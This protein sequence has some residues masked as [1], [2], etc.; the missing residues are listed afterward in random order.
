MS[1]ITG[2]SRSFERSLADHE[3]RALRLMKES[4]RRAA[5]LRRAEMERERLRKWN[6]TTTP[7]PR[8]A[9]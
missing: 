9:D 7:R 4:A 1:T 6:E 5:D 8:C 3:A 2:F